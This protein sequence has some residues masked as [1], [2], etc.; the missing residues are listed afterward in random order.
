[1][2]ARVTMIFQVVLLCFAGVTET[3]AQQTGT[4][5]VR[6]LIVFFDGLRPDYI[7]AAAMPNLYAFK[8]Q[9]A[10]G[11]RHHSVY[12]SVTRLNAASYATGSYPGMHGIMGNTI[13]FPQVSTNKTLNTGDAKD[14][15][16]VAL[17]THDSLLTAVSVAEVLSAAGKNM[18]VF[19]SGSTGQ[20]LM[21]NH[22]IKGGGIINPDMIL[23][24][25]LKEKVIKALGDPSGQDGPNE[26]RH[27]WVTDAFLKYGLQKDGPL[28]SAVW[29]SDPDHAGHSYGMGSAQ[30]RQAIKTVDQQF[31]RILSA[32][33]E[34][35]L[36]EQ[37]NII[38]SAD[39][40]F[41]TYVG[42]QTL[43]GFLIEKGFKKDK[44]SDDVIAADGAIYIK[45]KNPKLV[46]DIVRALQQQPWIGAVFTK[47][48]KPG[49]MNGWVTGTLSYD[50]VHWNHATRAADILVD[51]NW[52]NTVNSAGYA[53]AGYSKGV[54][55]HGGLSP[56]EIKIPL[57]VSGPGFIKHRVSDIPTSNVD[58][59]PT[60]LA[61]YHIPVP[62]S[63]DGRVM[64]E[65]MT[66]QPGEKTKPKEEIIETK[67]ADSWG[68]YRLQLTITRY[69]KYRY[70]DNAAVKRTF[71]TK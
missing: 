31:G 16:K 18:M 12:P 63:M 3:D 2:I 57:I 39:H 17:A 61:L 64:R 8:L 58:L 70:V 23:P 25:S 36:M 69:G 45:E 15:N 54:A 47:A 68:T 56:Y 19:S 10:Y 9:G 30:A 43:T 66:G 71:L 65:L 24:E 62:A 29:F 26:E 5:E 55:G 38:V 40:G 52:D 28:V 6:T 42:K 67:A 44:E 32:L 7:T 21:Q 35:G 33:K 34:R 59:V 60:V 41:V 49:D 13:F 27:V 1:M 20:A 53:G 14:L 4:T 37:F 46:R 11:N 51:R 50:A 48:A 22:K